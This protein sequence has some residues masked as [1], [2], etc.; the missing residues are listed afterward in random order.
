LDQRGRRRFIRFWYG[1]NNRPALE[2]KVLP[3]RRRRRVSR[4]REAA[5]RGA[6]RPGRL[7]R[8]DGRSPRERR[9]GVARAGSA[10]G[11]GNRSIARAAGRSGS[12]YRRPGTDPAPVAVVLRPDLR[13]NLRDGGGRGAGRPVRAFVEPRRGGARAAARV[14]HAAPPRPDA[15]ADRGDAGGGRRIA[16]HARRARRPCHRRGDQPGAG[17]RRQP[18]VVQLGNGNA[19]PAGLAFHIDHHLDPLIGLDRCPVGKGSN[20]HGPGARGAGGL[21]M[22]RRA[23]LGGLTVL[24]LVSWADTAV[25]PR[26]TPGKSFVFP[27]DHGAHPEFRTE[28]W[29]V[30]G[31]LDGPLGFQITFFRA[32]PE[33]QSNNPSSFNPRQI[34]LAHAALADPKRGELLTDQRAARAGFSLAHAEL[35]RTGVWV[36]DWRLELEGDRYQARISGRDLDFDLT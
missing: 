24:P 8:L 31:W 22:R 26:V 35:D 13:R 20:E 10:A 33:E 11:S 34:I 36:D 4:L 12:R 6:D 14:R 25:Y 21:V 17:V 5:R 23:F 7:H 28:W 16:R 29:Y 19:F 2:R 18:P 15:P 3:L 9:R 32:R 1:E 27:R 30:T